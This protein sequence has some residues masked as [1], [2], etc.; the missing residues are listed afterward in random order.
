MFY[1]YVRD[2]LERF[3]LLCQLETRIV[4]SKK[5]DVKSF[6]EHSEMI[7]LYEICINPP[8]LPTRS[9]SDVLPVIIPA[10]FFN[11]SE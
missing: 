8:P 9:R 11:Y 10:E 1:K 5:H 7:A 3:Y 2:N 6:G 4:P